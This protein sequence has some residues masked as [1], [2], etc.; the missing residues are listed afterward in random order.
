[1]NQTATPEKRKRKLGG[2]LMKM[3]FLFL[4]T[5]GVVL[6][7][8]L[9]N[10]RGFPNPGQPLLPVSEELTVLTEPLDDNGDVDY[11][12]ALN[13]KYSAGVTTESNAMVKFAQALGPRTDKTEFNTEFCRRLGIPELPVKPATGN[14]FKLI[15]RWR[16]DA[17]KLI[18]E[19]SAQQN[20]NS[21]MADPEEMERIEAQLAE[22][23]YAE[24]GIKKSKSYD[25]GLDEPY[26]DQASTIA[27]YAEDLSVQYDFAQANPWSPEELPAVEKWL[28]Y[29]TSAIK[30]VEEGLARPD[31]YHPL[32]STERP[33]VMNASL[34]FPNEYRELSRYYSARA[35]MNLHQG[36][37]EKSLAD[38]DSQFRL[39]EI[40]A[41]GP[42]IVE[43]LI[44]IAIAGNARSSALQVAIAPNTSAAQLAQLQQR[45]ANV[46]PIGG[47]VNRVDEIE[48]YT[49]LDVVLNAGRGRLADSILGQN[50]GA[51]PRVKFIS[52]AVDFRETIVVLNDQ[53]D[54]CIK[55]LRSAEAAETPEQRRAA[56]EEFETKMKQI[57]IEMVD[58]WEMVKT[59]AAGRKAKGNW[60]GRLLGGMLL[61]SVSSLR[62]AEIRMKSKLESSQLYVAVCRFRKDNGQLPESLEQLTPKYIDALPTDLFTDR[63][64]VYAK[65]ED[66]FRIHSDLW[67]PVDKYDD[68]P[69]YDDRSENAKYLL[70]PESTTWAEFLKSQIDEDESSFFPR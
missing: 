2:C 10:F 25:G 17:M 41:R 52:R 7:W 19:E 35:M 57:E 29:N 20:P 34:S 16:D 53:Y 23:I 24:L 60:V 8:V 15:H 48:R 63:P 27:R 31:Y 21:Y 62:M 6:V 66:G 65:T 37:V 44:G 50:A 47:L 13:Q 1:M 9:F 3:F 46:T 11:L 14:Y 36:N 49:G 51:T 4:M 5:L 43:E 32:I 56:A 55:F 64:F 12:E 69:V 70:Q 18:E 59:V 54:L 22:K 45:L 39:A 58:P 42:T 30:T 67:P 33:R 26:D 38:I 28:Q 61:P 68:E 40:A